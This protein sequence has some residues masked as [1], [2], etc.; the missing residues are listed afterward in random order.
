MFGVQGNSW[1]GLPEN[2]ELFLVQVKSAFTSSEKV[3]S[4]SDSLL[5]PRPR[6]AQRVWPDSALQTLAECPSASHLPSPAWNLHKRRGQGRPAGSAECSVGLASLLLRPQEC[7]HVGKAPVARRPPGASPGPHPS[8]VR[9]QR[10]CWG[11]AGTPR[12]SPHTSHL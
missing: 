6:E 10:G 4:C 2:D 1:P 12:A 5:T 3:S 9:M 11:K 8:T 7:P